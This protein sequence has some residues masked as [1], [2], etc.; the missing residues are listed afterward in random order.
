LGS[1]FIGDGGDLT[2]VDGAADAVACHS[3][4]KVMPCGRIEILDLS[5]RQ[6]RTAIEFASGRRA[7]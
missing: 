4:A 7:S 6:R 1:R 2:A 5:C 3:Q